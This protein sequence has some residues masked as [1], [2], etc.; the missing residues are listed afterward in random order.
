MSERLSKLFAPLLTES[1]HHVPAYCLV[2]SSDY[3][4]VFINHNYYPT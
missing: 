3:I 4:D 2:G 1:L